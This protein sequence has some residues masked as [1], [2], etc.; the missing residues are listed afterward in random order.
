[1]IAIDSSVAIAAFGEWHELHEAAASIVDGGAAIPAH[2]LLET[3]SVLSGFPPPHR[4]P[5]GIVDSWLEDRF[6]HILPP[7][8]AEEQRELVRQL[9]R[10]DRIGGATYDAL[11]AL[12]AKIAGA[13]LATGDRRAIP[14]YDLVGVQVLRLEVEDR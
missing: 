2:A 5:A 8:N 14:V 7:P 3:Y 13:T 9:A 11:V 12:T 1:V 10:A 4:A 6:P